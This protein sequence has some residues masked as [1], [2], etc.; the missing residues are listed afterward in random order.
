MNISQ[1]V[2]PNLGGQRCLRR[3]D[4]MDALAPLAESGYGVEIGL[5]RYAKRHNWCVE[6]VDWRGTTQIM[7]EDKLGWKGALKVRGVMYQEIMATWSR[8]MVPPPKQIL[9]NRAWFEKLQRLLE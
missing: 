2:F 7:Q 6:Y 8:N 3:D 4:A 9:E 5:T 1:L